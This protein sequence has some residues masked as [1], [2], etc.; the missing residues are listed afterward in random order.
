MFD[1]GERGLSALIKQYYI[2]IVFLDILNF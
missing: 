2:I 1:E